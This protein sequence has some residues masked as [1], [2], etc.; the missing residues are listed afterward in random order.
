MDKSGELG[1]MPKEISKENVEGAIY[2]YVFPAY[3]K[4]SEDGN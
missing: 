3:N 4:T 2:I 1:N